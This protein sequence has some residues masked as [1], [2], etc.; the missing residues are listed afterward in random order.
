[1]PSIDPRDR[2]ERDRRLVA[3]GLP[4]PPPAP[5]HVAVVQTR[6][7]ERLLHVSGQV[8]MAAD[9]L[10]AT[11]VVGADIDLATAQACARQ[12]AVNLLGRAVSALG[13]LGAVEHVAKLTVFVA[14]APGF[15]DQSEVANAASQVLVD[16]LGAQAGQHA[17]A[18]VGVAA[19]PLGSPVEVEALL[20]VVSV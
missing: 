10:V 7:S 15:T 3:L 16:V 8:A 11:G 18:A 1:M 13:S 6:R 14:S 9:R 2:H 4:L 5:P 17:R 20:L 12:C 19:L